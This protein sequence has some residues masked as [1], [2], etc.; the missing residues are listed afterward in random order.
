MRKALSAVASACRMM[1]GGRTRISWH[2]RP[3]SPPLS[4]PGIPEPGDGPETCAKPVCK[5]TSFDVRQASRL[6]FHC[7]EYCH[8]KLTNC[9]VY[10][11]R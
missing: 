4:V 1:G 3:E 11:L 9:L 7:F 10:L 8:T 5:Y 6:K 2:L